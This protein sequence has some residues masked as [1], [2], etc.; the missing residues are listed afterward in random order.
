MNFLD[1]L[2]AIWYPIIILLSY[3]CQVFVSLLSIVCR[4]QKRPFLNHFGCELAVLALGRLVVWSK[5]FN[6]YLVYSESDLKYEVS[7]SLPLFYQMSTSE[8]VE[9][10]KKQYYIR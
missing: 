4:A 7:K 10:L 6:F 5:L 1:L 2:K 8:V 9:F 3:N